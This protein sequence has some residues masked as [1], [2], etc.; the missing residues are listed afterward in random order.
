[1]LDIGTHFGCRRRSFLQIGSL[2]LGGLSFADLL[3]PNASA[4]HRS[5]LLT[6]KSVVFVFMHGGPSQ[7]ETFDP[8]MTAPPGVCSANGEIAT[9]LP[10]V[11]YGSAFPKLAALAHRTSIVR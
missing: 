4:A 10:G 2:A 3:A 9:T 6:G 8:K 1:M 7:I 5:Q 11:T